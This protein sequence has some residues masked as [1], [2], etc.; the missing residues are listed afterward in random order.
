MS[1]NFYDNQKIRR[2][3]GP[4]S[5]HPPRVA[6]RVVPGGPHPVVARSPLA[7]ARPFSEVY[8]ML[9]AEAVVDVSP[10]RP[11]A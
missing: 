2:A 11:E 4:T 9:P 6:G 8:R 5:D 10:R 1:S 7:E 3:P